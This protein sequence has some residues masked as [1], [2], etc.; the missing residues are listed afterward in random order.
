MAK[1]VVKWNSAALRVRQSA[2]TPVAG[3]AT[4]GGV[5]LSSAN[6]TCIW[7]VNVRSLRTAERRAELY[8]R[9]ATGKPRI[10]LI[11]ET[12]LDSATEQI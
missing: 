11:Q 7:S 5:E 10:L 6:Y 12:W 1:R 2:P 9:I 8:F 3:E 4:I